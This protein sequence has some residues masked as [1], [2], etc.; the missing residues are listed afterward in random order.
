MTTNIR[1]LTLALMLSL[2]TTPAA[3]ASDR[4]DDGANART[5]AASTLAPSRAPIVWHAVPAERLTAPAT[6]RPAALMP[7]YVSAGVLQAMDLYTTSRGMKGGAHETNAL[8]RK[9]NSGTTM[10]LKA[11]TTAAGIVLAEKLWKKNKA[12]AILSMVAANAITSYAVVNNY[13][14]IGQLER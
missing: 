1:S 9:G 13:R 10:A 11:A 6:E 2:A 4:T 12:A 5:A 7:L 3:F 14:V 8:I